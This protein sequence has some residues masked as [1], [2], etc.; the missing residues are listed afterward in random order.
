MS[1]SVRTS[2]GTSIRVQRLLGTGGQGEVWLADMAGSPVAIK[3]YHRHIATPAQRAVIERL[4]EKGPPSKHFLWPK[5]LVNDRAS[6][7]Y[8]YVM[9]LREKRFH[10]LEDFMARRI[11]PGFRALL[12]AAWQLA[13]AFLRLHSQGWCYRDISFGNVFFDP[14]N[15]DVRICDND[16]VDIAETGSGGI[17]GTPR[18]MAPE[19]VRREAVPSDQTDRYSLAVLL[20]YM[21]MGG[22]PLDGE[23]EA[24]IRCLDVPALEK[25]YG[26]EPVYI[27]D[28][29]NKSNKPVPGVHENPI[30]FYPIYPSEIHEL[31]LRSFTDG[32]RYPAKRVRE[33]EWRK[34]FARA[35]DSVFPCGCRADNFFN[36]AK[37]QAQSAGACWACKRALPLPL[38]IRFEKGDVVLTRDT[39]LCGRHVGNPQ[40]DEEVIAEVTQNPTNPALF[41]LRNQGSTGVWTFTRADGSIVDVPPGKSVPIVVGNKINFGQVTGEI[42]A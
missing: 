13:D 8:G 24:K 28:P 4:I 16:N 1:R 3:L 40:D 26:F 25:L 18:F 9:D 7:A 35:I 27:F 41:G 2:D 19:V 15:G 5:A 30:A 31:F 37:V 6:S 42:C 38:R 20:F 11:E 29:T 21:L 10:S 14:S 33:S 34:A 17:L 32:L 39:R 23:R 22:H 36:P 12:T